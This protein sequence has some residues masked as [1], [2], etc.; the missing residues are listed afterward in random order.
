MFEQRDGEVRLESDPALGPE[1]AHLVFI[2]TIVS[3]WQERSQCPKNMRQARERQTQA[4]VQI[5]QPFR[6]GLSRLEPGSAIV[7]LSWLSHAP[8]DL[9]MQKPRFSERVHGTFSLRSP[10]R[11]NPIG[12]HFVRLLEIDADKGE[13]IIDAIDTLNG[14]PLLDIKPWFASTDIV[15]Q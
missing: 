13:L 3:P 11:P 4:S 1:D 15:G 6:A 5:D 2:G 12:L 9:I 7:L 14:T 8:R 10:A